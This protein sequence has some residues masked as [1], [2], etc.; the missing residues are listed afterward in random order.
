MTPPTTSVNEPAAP[1]RRIASIDIVRG[2]V[3]ALMMID[4]VRENFYLQHQ[5]ADPVDLHASGLP[6]FFTRWVSHI[7]APAFVLL[8]GLAV[9]I[10]RA[11]RGDNARTTAGYLVRRG[12]FLIVLEVTVVNFGWMF[13]FPPTIVFLQVIWAIGLSM[14]ALAGLIYLPPRVLL[15]VSLVIIFGHNLLD[16]ITAG[17]ASLPVK[18]VWSILHERTRNLLWDGFTL[19][20]SYPVLPY[21]GVIG[22][23]Y[24][25]G[26]LYSGEAKPEIRRAW[27][28]AAGSAA[29]VLFLVLRPLNVYGEKGRFVVGDSAVATLASLLNTTKYPPSLLYL[30]MTLG[31]TLVLLAITERWRG[32]VAAALARFGTAPLLY[33]VLHIYALHTASCLLAR[34]AGRTGLYQ[35]DRVSSIWV[36]TVIALA[37][38]APLSVSLAD[39][40]RRLRRRGR[41]VN[42]RVAE[43]SLV[44]SDHRR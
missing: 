39:R 23:G 3:M 10:R 14:V 26:R 30:L 24:A 29:I 7:C 43:P 41:T 5:V 9:A 40:V 11:R 1:A 17:R 28:L 12:L 20:V 34:L 13:E 42:P 44:A 4:H 38:I 31:P 19:R 2:L 25:L 27:L 32:P 6:L 35:F 8:A 37:I 18:L 22:L 16:P 15:G 36:T 33:Y 21:V